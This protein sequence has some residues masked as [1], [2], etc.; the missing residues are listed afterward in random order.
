MIGPLRSFL[1]LGFTPEPDFVPSSPAPPEAERNVVPEMGMPSVAAPVGSDTASAS[2]FTL[3]NLGCLLVFIMGALLPLLTL[4]PSSRPSTPGD[5]GLAPAS[6]NAVGIVLGILFAAA[7]VLGSLSVFI[8]FLR[9][10]RN[11]LYWQLACW[12][13]VVVGIVVRQLVAAQLGVPSLSQV[14]VSIAV[15][16]AVLPA[17]MRWLN[18]VSPKPGVQHAAVPFSLGFFLDLAQVLT[19][20]YVVKLPW[21]PS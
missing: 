15:G 1:D 7:V 4:S 3:I 12:V 10:R 19:S 16:V 20:S 17:L 5:P 21:I 11:P 13:L 18:R 2:S 9:R 6:L 8:R 14:L